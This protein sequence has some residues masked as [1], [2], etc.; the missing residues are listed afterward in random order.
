MQKSNAKQKIVFNKT[1]NNIKIIVREW[2]NIITL[3]DATTNKVMRETQF[4]DH[5]T[6]VYFAKKLA[7]NN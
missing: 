5:I 2:S 6:A 7:G 4:T 3:I 1:K